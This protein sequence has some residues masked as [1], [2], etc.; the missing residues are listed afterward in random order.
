MQKYAG[1]KPG[2]F[3]YLPALFGGEKSVFD[4][5]LISILGLIVLLDVAIWIYGP[6]DSL[7]IKFYYTGDQARA[8]ML[9]FDQ[10]ELRKYLATALL[11]LALIF[12]YTTALVIGLKRVYASRTVALA[13]F[14][15][16]VCD[17]IET[18]AI[19]Y[20]IVRPG[21]YA[22]FDW[23]GVVTLLKWTFGA[24]LFAVFAV[25]LALPKT[26]HR[27]GGGRS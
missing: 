22:F 19:L 20:F 24:I 4:K 9:G 27:S 15:P 26:G 1:R 11:D 6:R 25:G 8:L 23:L 17:F 7:D 14:L 16:G 3:A 10:M 2:Q 18:A 13:G 5:K 21:P 12:S